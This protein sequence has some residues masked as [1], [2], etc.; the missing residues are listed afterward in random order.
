M[1]SQ[2]RSVLCIFLSLFLS[3]LASINTSP[4]Y[5]HEHHMSKNINVPYVK[6]VPGVFPSDICFSTTA[7]LTSHCTPTKFTTLSSA[8]LNAATKN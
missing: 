4:N 1:D 7:L 2:L 6:A 5:Q 8:S 3:H